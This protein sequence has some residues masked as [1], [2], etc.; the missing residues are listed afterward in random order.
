MYVGYGTYGDPDFYQFT[1]G[2]ASI[3]YNVRS[4]RSEYN[5]RRQGIMCELIVQGELSC[6][7]GDL[8]TQISDFITAFAE[9]YKTLALYRD[10]NTM[11]NH[12]LNIADANLVDGPWIDA[13]SWPK[14]D[15]GEYASQRTFYIHGKA[16]FR[17]TQSAADYIIKYH[18]TIRIR[19]NGGPKVA[20]LYDQ[21]GNFVQPQIVP[22]TPVYVTQSGMSIGWQ[23]YVLPL[24]PVNPTYLQ[25]ELS[26]EAPETGIQLSN[27]LGR[28]QMSWQ[29]Q[30]VQPSYAFY[31]P[32][33]R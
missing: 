33:V 31:A 27:G 4:V 28:Y 7:D 20:R 23:G 16:L 15:R 29:Y 24:G 14:G 1:A 11:T 3:I 9:D 18:E 26:I 19:G 30:M 10:D 22:N 17:S 6:L 32:T 21:A 25:N 13:R 8:D 5:N 2:R 12:A